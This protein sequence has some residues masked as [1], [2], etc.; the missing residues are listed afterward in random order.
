MYRAQVLTWWVDGDRPNR[1]H[2]G[3]FLK[4]NGL[5]GDISDAT[6]QP[7]ANIKP[8]PN[9][10]IVEIVCPLA[11]FEAIEAHPDYGSAAILWNEEIDEIA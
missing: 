7:Y 9:L 8:A 3:E 4:A 5:Q 2:L 6:G 10:F 11:T 1:I